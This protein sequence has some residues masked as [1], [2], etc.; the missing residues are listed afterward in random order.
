[1]RSRKT[2]NSNSLTLHTQ[3]QPIIRAARIINAVE[4]DDAGFDK[5]TQL[6]QVMPIA[7]V[8]GEP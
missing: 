1:M 6:K 5:T 8:T 3:K 2:P 7:A 4:I